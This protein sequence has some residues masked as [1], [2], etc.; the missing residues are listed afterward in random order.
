VLGE[1]AVD[2][3]KM[4]VDVIMQGPAYFLATDRISG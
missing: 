1:D 4:E 2:R 3:Q